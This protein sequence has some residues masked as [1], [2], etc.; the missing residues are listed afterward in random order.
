M[1]T[2]ELFSLL[3]HAADGAFVTDGDGQILYWGPSAQDTFGLPS[4]R[5]EGR[6]CWEL[7]EASGC[8]ASATC[9]IDCLSR[10]RAATLSP[11]SSRNIKM[12][13]NEGAKW[14][15]VSFLGVP[16]SDRSTPVVVHF[17]RDIDHAKRL[18][19]AASQCAEEMR[20]IAALT[21]E[22]ERA[23]IALTRREGEILNLCAKGKTSKQIAER[24]GIASVTVRN[25]VQNILGKLECHS[26]VEAVLRA[27]DLGQL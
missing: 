15:S 6:R 14:F 1:T 5:S 22:E 19:D 11:T 26:R 10:A 18:Q 16:V 12:Q 4:K 3:K 8:P 25:H 21:F 20:R 17:C 7:L 24:L 23:P 13:A 2:R 27:R 9:S